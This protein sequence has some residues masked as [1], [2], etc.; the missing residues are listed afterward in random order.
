MKRSRAIFAAAVWL[1]VAYADLA[2]AQGYAGEAATME[3]TAL[4]DKP[5]AGMLKRGGYMAGINMYQNGGV[6]MNVSAGVWDWFMFGISYGG[7]NIIGTQKIRMNPYPGVN[8]KI[9]IID[10]SIELPAI[11]FGFD[12]QGK[13]SYIDGLERYSTKSP[14]FFAVASKNYTFLGNLSFHGGAN[15]SLERGDGDKDL[16]IYCGIEKSAG[17][18]L[19]LLLEYDFSANDN[20]GQAVGRGRGYL[21]FGLRWSL[22]S[23]MVLGCNLKDLLKNQRGITFANRSLQLDYSG[24]F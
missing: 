22:G 6:L 16:N 12:S 19:S 1:S 5:T 17:N 21:N 24:I 20:H 8:V 13:D 2:H 4:I 10:E 7:N 3:P 15:L 18:D 23:G 9:R 11:A 14:G